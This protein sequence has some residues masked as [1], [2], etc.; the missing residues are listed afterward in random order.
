MKKSTS[1]TLSILINITALALL[2]IKSQAQFTSSGAEQISRGGSWNSAPDGQSTDPSSAPNGDIVA[3]SSRA[4]NLVPGDTNDLSDVFIYTP[5]RK[6]ELVSVPVGV[7]PQGP[8]RGSGAPNVSSLLPDGQYAVAFTSDA[9]N[10]VPNYIVPPN[11]NFNPRQVYLRFPKLGKTLLVSRGVG[12]NPE[13]VEGANRPC[14]SV[15]VVAQ[16]D[17][18]RFIVAFRS[19]ATNLDDSPQDRTVETI[20]VVRVEFD[21]TEPAIKRVEAPHRTPSGSILEHPLNNPVLSGNGRFVAF[22]SISQMEDGGN[23]SARNEQIYLFDYTGKRARMISRDA[24]GRPGDGDS[25]QPS[26]SYQ[27]DFLAFITRATNIVP[28]TINTPMAVLFSAPTKKITQVNSSA[29]SEASNGQVYAVSISPGGKLVAFADD[30]TNLSKV[31]S[32]PGVIQTYVKEPA[33][34]VILRTSTTP[35]GAPADQN[36][37]AHTV[38]LPDGSTPMRPSLSFGGLGFNSR[39]TYTSF[40]SLAQ[41]LKAIPS[42]DTYTNVYRTTI[43]PPKPKFSRNAPIEAPPDATISSTLPNGQG[44]TVVFQLQEFELASANAAYQSKASAL[45]ESS[46]RLTYSLE[47]RKSGAKQRIFR[48]SSRNTVTVRKLAPGS[49][50]VRYRVIKTSGRTVTKTQYSPKGSLQIT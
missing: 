25:F 9:P 28:R 35:A 10:L 47:I 34:G 22:S 8:I 18:N 30:G 15:S 29:S 46:A 26:L 20:F 3:F 23:Q 5:D 48:T 7:A 6:I 40:G 1:V 42:N 24:S 2:S 4:T 11:S 50:T 31:T 43:T 44:A 12:S 38:E 17:P 49:Y 33:S 16:A 19:A 39:V 13:Q 32:L 14:D 21:G 37:G 45:A 36:S 27:G 41:N